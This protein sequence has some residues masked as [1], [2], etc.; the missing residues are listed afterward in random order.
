MS[1]LSQRASPGEGTPIASPYANE[2]IL[3]EAQH[4]G[5]E[6]TSAPRV[7]AD[8]GLGVVRANC[9]SLFLFTGRQHRAAVPRAADEGAPA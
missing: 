6:A 5:K 1:L 8:E 7:A 2:E 9:M 3:K 4:P